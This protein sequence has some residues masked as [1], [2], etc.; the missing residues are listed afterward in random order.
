MR[1]KGLLGFLCLN[2]GGWLG[3][4]LGAQVGITTAVLISAIGS[5]L[6]LWGFRVLAERLLE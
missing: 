3:W 2:V 6:G 4:W 5:G 1:L